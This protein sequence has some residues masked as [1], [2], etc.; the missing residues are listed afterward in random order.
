MGMKK[1]LLTEPIRPKGI[2]LLENEVELTIAQNRDESAVAA[3]IGEYDAVITRTTRITKEIIDQGKKLVVIGR[4][5]A[6]LDIVELDYA[7]QRGVCLVHTPA[8]NARSV[9]EYVIGLMLASARMI[10][11]A[12]YAQRVERDFSTRNNFMG[13]DLENRTVGIVGMGRIGRY[14]AKMCKYG[15]DMKVLG[16]DPYVT[17]EELQTIGVEKVSDI[18]EI[19]RSS[20]FVSLNCPLTEEVK[21]LVDRAM[22]RTMKPNAYLINCARG[23]IVDEQALREALDNGVIRGAALDVFAVEPPPKDNVLFDAPNLIAT[24]HI[25]TMTHESMDLM[26]VTVAQ[27]VLSALRGEKPQFLANPT[28]WETRRS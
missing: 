2:E 20:D 15:F 9:A 4:H 7:T 11:P 5:G 18:A 25:A 17:A 28:V 27:G 6:G 22:L 19:F 13:H 21:G 14:V 3:I 16:Y 1:V 10:I 8:A 12:D 24:P 26:S 23:P